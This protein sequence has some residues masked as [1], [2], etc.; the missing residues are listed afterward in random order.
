MLSED[1]LLNWSGD[2][3]SN[4]WHQDFNVHAVKILWTAA[5]SLLFDFLKM[6]SGFLSKFKKN[7]NTVI[8]LNSVVLECWQK[9]KM[10]RI[11]IFYF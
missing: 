7:K 4:G 1:F 3:S 11:S 10:C 9:L 8:Y 6:H 2:G 5:I